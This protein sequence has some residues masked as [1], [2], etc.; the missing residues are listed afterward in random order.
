MNPARFASRQSGAVLLLTVMLAV[1]GGFAY[2]N[3]PS[4]I[5][6]PLEFPRI[7]VIAHS[8]STP[9]RSMTL[10]VARPIE[11]AI[12]EVPGIRR[13]RSRTFR[14]ATEISAQF[15]P[16]TDT[17]VALQMVQNRI[18]EIRADLPTDADLVVDRQTPAVFPIYDLNLTGPLS[19]A[20]LNDYGFYV[21]RPALS[22]VPG[23][24]HVGVAASDVREVE[25]VVDPGKLLAA[26]LTVDDVSAA[27]KGANLLQPIGH[28]PENGLQRLVLASGLWTSLN[29]I[30]AT[31]VVVKGGTTLRI[32]DLAT[33]R[34]GAPDRTSMITGQGG[35]ATAI[36]VSQQVGANILSVR[37]GLE[38]ALAQLRST[39]PGGLKLVKTYDLAE[40]VQS[41]IANVRDA[42]LIGAAL[43]VLVLLFFLRNWRLTIVAACSLPLTVIS[44]FLFMRL[45][46]ETIN[47]MSMGG[48]AVAI[49][50]VID[51]AVVVVE[52]IHRHMAN[53]DSEPIERATGEL[54]GPVV[55]STLTTVVVFAPLGLLSGVV[56]DFFRALSITLS[57]AVLISMVLALYLIPLLARVSYR[58]AGG[59]ARHEDQPGAID[60]WYVRTLPTI[61]KRPVLALTAAALLVVAAVAA[62]MP[63][64]SGFLPAADE[65]GFVIDYLTPAGMALEETDTRL[66]KVEAILGETPEVATYVRRTGSELGMFATQMNSGDVLVRLK[67]RG[68]R[69]RSAD[70][71]IGDLR[72]KL[73]AAV[74]DTEIEFVQLLQDMLGDLEGNPTPIEVKIFGDDQTQ[75]ADLSEQVET[76]LEKIAGVVDIVGLEEGGPESTWT[77]DPVAAGRIG[78]SVGEVATQLSNAWLGTVATDLRLHDRTVPVRVRYPDA[79]RFNPVTL[80]STTV[81]GKDGQLTPASAL[82]SID[83]HAG[84]PE[85]MREN[86]RSMA[87]VSARLDH[88]DLG[89]AVTEIKSMLAGMQLPVGYTWEVGGQYES[90]RRSFRELLLVAGIATAL[91][92]LVLVIQ[93]R[94][95]TA[96]LVIIAAAPLSLGG[97]FTLLLLTG[98][99]LNVSS[100]MGLI[101]LV[102]LVV[103]NGI[104]LL[105]FAELRHA[106]GVP[107]REAVLSAA[108]VRLRPILM[109]TL[110]TLFGLLPLALGIGAGAELQKPLALAVIGG[111]TL[112]TLVTLYLV[113][114]A[115]L[116]FIGRRSKDS[117]TLRQHAIL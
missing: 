26:R 33:V 98:T 10:T 24:G 99:D 92:F 30:A 47:L 117:A 90:Q 41:A 76:K 50:L 81:R 57:V 15:D 11:Q 31:P 69:S 52:N 27:L 107:I 29:D 77:V 61:V 25:V 58:T 38:D 103:K 74:P 45:F 21:I 18:A 55:G 32:S 113:P 8:G 102:G 75:L 1:A 115:Y 65:G 2:W 93:F 53:H 87:L 5:Y 71:V 96:S 79:Q 83:D 94:G 64:G 16:G 59:G 40:F 66:K 34:N 20:E 84:D 104:V 9:A 72:D 68:E 86:L 13:V 12:M 60:R 116:A 70:A 14:G 51:D 95:F 73:T 80:A 56:G 114:A 46:G 22:R 63:L 110:C 6:P 62:Y 108:R 4:S 42:I 35:N 3:L 23:V 85:L 17:V 78:L 109:T 91:V 88:R 89:G 48:L 19:P 54:V 106:E 37:E 44:T 82:V 7:V 39:L 111:L 36:S 97:A 28:Y 100:A 49:G 105:D 43:A 112:S 101:L 67:P